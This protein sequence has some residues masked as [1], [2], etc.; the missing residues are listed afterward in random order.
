MSCPS[1]IRIQYRLLRTG[2]C[3]AALMAVASCSTVTGSGYPSMSRPSLNHVDTARF[4]GPDTSAL[5]RLS[6]NDVV[7]GLVSGDYSKMT[8][9]PVELGIPTVDKSADTLFHPSMSAARSTNDAALATLAGLRLGTDDVALPPPLVPQ[10]AVYDPALVA[11]KSVRS[12]PS[13]VVHWLSKN[14][15]KLYNGL[16]AALSRERTSTH[17]A[18]DS[19]ATGSVRPLHIKVQSQ[20]RQVA[21]NTQRSK[22]GF[23]SW[24]LKGGDTSRPASTRPASGVAGSSAQNIDPITTASVGT[25]A[26]AAGASVRCQCQCQFRCQCR[27]G[28]DSRTHPHGR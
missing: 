22:P 13:S 21:D 3:I 27:S 26:S 15:A 8:P 9:R 2:V 7:R 18:V 24:I 19:V 4:K 11:A 16:K 20:T 12:S 10:L 5:S 28:P 23:W 17:R 14:Q 6:V 25:V 1:T